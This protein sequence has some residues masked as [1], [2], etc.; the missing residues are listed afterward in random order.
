VKSELFEVLGHMDLLK[1]FKYLPKTDIRLLAKE[2]IATLKNSQMVVE[3]NG[4]GFR[5]PIGEQYP[6]IPLLE[7]LYE[8][9]IPITFGSDAHTPMQVGLELETN[10]AIARKIGFEPMVAFKSREREVLKF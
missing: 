2:L 8:N 1:L 4:A 7:M 3:V 9:N 5:K 10:M 6:M